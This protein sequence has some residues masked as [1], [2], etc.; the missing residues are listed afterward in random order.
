MIRICHRPLF[1]RLFHR[2]EP[3]FALLGNAKLALQDGD[4]EQGD[5][6]LRESLELS[7]RAGFQR[8][9]CAARLGLSEVAGQQGDMLEAQVQ[10]ERAKTLALKNGYANIT[11]RAR[12]LNHS[13]ATG[14]E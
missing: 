3:G 2:Y 9:E 11:N 8:L 6:Q 1:H 14:N 4:T 5:V 10:M 7:M 13:A 12:Q